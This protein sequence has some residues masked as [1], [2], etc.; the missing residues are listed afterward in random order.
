MDKMIDKNKVYV[1]ECKLCGEILL[2]RSKDPEYARILNY[3]IEKKHKHVESMVMSDGNIT[4]VE[5]EAGWTMDENGE[6]LYHNV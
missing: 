3:H 1:Y 4:A 5:M 2:S 6:R